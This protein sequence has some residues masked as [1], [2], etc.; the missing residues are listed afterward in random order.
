MKQLSLG[1]VLAAAYLGTSVLAIAQAPP[2]SRGPV[3]DCSQIRTKD[4]RADDYMKWVATQWKAQEE[5]L[6]KGGFAI[7]YK[8]LS[9]VDARAGE[10]NILLCTEFKDMAAF[11]T[12]DAKVQAFMAKQFGS[13]SK[14]DQQEVARGSMRTVMGDVMM[15][16]LNLK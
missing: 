10:P 12:P 8:V 4:G 9:T 15:R 5:A 3:W 6:I 7:G 16:Q 2:Y 14:A 1:A 13:L 11:D